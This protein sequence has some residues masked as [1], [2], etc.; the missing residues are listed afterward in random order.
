M[1]SRARRGR[2]S[3]WVAWL[4]IA[5]LAVVV[6]DD[7]HADGLVAVQID[8]A[9]AGRTILGGPDAIGGVG[10]WALQNG[11]L[12]AVVADPSHETDA[13]T[14]GGALI[15]LGLCGRDDDQMI[16]YLEL[17]DNSA[18]A[19]VRA[20]RI[21][22][23]VDDGEASLVVEG[24]Q[25]GISVDT[26]YSV[27]LEEPRRLRIRTTVTRGDDA[28][29]LSGFSGAVLNFRGLTPFSVSTGGE[30]PSFGYVYPGY[31]D[32]GLGALADAATPVDL[33]VG[34]GAAGLAPGIA[35]GLRSTAAYVRDG[36]GEKTDV[37]RFFLSDGF[38]TI[39]VA[40]TETFLFGDDRDL[41]YVG[42][43]E[44]AFM[45]L[46]EGHELVLEQEIWVGERSDVAAV[47][48][49]L[50]P[51]AP[52]VTGT[53]DAA[54]AVVHVDRV[55]GG[56]FTEV[57]LDEPGRFSM[58]LPAGRYVLRVVAPGGRSREKEIDVGPDGGRAGAFT[59]AAPS[60]VALPA[61]SPMRL[62]FVGIDGTDDPNFRD[63]LRGYR[64]R[65][66]DGEPTP[67]L[68]S[69]RSIHLAGTK[70]DPTSVTL[71]P[72]RYRVLATRG[73]E[74]SLETTTLEVAPGAK[75]TLEIDPPRRVVETP[76]EVGSDFH[77]HSA[78][79]LD[80]A[81]PTSRQIASTVASGSEVLVSSEHDHVVD[82]APRI[83]EMGLGEDL[84]SVVGLEVTSEVSSDVAPMSIG[85]ANVF[86][87]PVQPLAYRRGAVA[88]EG[89]RWRDVIADLRALPGQRV[90]QLNH[91]ETRDGEPDK[92]AFF[93]HMGPAAAAFERDEPLDAA[94]NDVLIE[95]DSKTSLRD[96]DFDA[97]E[98]LN[99][100]NME[101]Y[102]VLRE[103]WF[104]LL[105]HG[106]RI[107][108]T[109][110]SDSH[111]PSTP[112][113]TPRNYVRYDGEVVPASGFDEKRFVAAVREGRL[114]GTTGPIVDVELDGARPGDTART[115]SATLAIEVRAADWIPVDEVRVYVSGALVAT[116][117]VGR[118][119][120]V[121]I[122]LEFEED[123]FV[124]TEVWGEPSEDYETVL[125]GFTPFAFTNPI[126]V[127]T[128]S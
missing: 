3:V 87:M 105:R 122:P 72:G 103:D 64:F 9:N 56:P 110:N 2:G 25:D 119:R 30:L 120:R 46:P 71:R 29:S 4:C 115:R 96:L 6:G 101:R 90:I 104:A 91:A 41:G 86:P 33:V 68:P 53:V 78:P 121:E 63:D 74:F 51:D 50:F 65:N 43:V 21:E 42:L 84:P 20:S 116:R 95:R 107:V 128:G 98:L 85:H 22:A 127:E 82:F 83:R 61:G 89:R 111:F 52:V 7:A 70:A 62:V 44:S 48:D 92:R 67:I 58:H 69:E 75:T 109:A 18:E 81:T 54:P 45:N 93:T 14:T 23:A 55:D 102:E 123:A 118:G 124:T 106:E 8:A 113:A 114:Y 35:Y 1:S 88:N 57:R 76:G 24:G 38:A 80:N 60:R 59:L 126:W 125:P 108:G 47:T 13:A 40:F 49:L 27:D 79:S 112:V 100:S 19:I 37:P 77:I 36:S 99:G 5:T 12:C 34:V 10:D 94:P 15:D 97:M 73:P 32:R 28:A 39:N 17:L 26:R 11:T 31:R 117:N 16:L 66:D